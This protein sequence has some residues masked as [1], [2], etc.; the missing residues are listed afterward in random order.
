[1]KKILICLSVLFLMTSCE[2]VLRNPEGDI[3]LKENYTKDRRVDYVIFNN[4]RYVR[5]KHF[6]EASICH[7]PECPFC[8]T[9]TQ[10]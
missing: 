2:P 7:D 3:I 5:Y 4:H 10:N 9:S 1:M 6:K 8:K